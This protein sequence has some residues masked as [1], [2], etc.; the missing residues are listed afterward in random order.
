MRILA[1]NASSRRDPAGVLDLS[2]GR[3]FGFGGSR[4]PLLQG[5]LGGVLFSAGF[6]T[7]GL[8]GGFAEATLGT[9]GGEE[10]RTR[11][12]LPATG[13]E[14]L[15]RLTA[16]G[17]AGSGSLTR[18]KRKFPEREDFT[19]VLFVRGSAAGSRWSTS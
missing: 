8:A 1:I 17:S 15:A 14:D 10:I 4:K 19:R 2:L 5:V 7:D 3:F 16:P 12:A 11:V 13:E 9:G 6:G 18:E